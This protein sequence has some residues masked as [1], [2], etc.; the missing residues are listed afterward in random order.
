[1]MSSLQHRP[2][3]LGRLMFLGSLFAVAPASLAG[4]D[5][6]AAGA[7]AIPRRS[8]DV[9][10]VPTEMGTVHTMLKVAQ[11][12]KRDTVYDLGCGDGRIVITAVKEYGARR[13]VC[14]D[15][16]PERIK[17]SRLKADSA[18]VTKRIAFREADLFEMD[19]SKATVITL[20]LLPAL[21]E[22]LRPKLFRELRPGTRIVSNSFDMGDWKADS[23]LQPSPRSQFFNYAY[24][25]VIP[26]DVAGA[27][28]VT[29]EGGGGGTE[30]HGRSY[31]LKLEQRYQQI[32]GKASAN[33]R[34]VALDEVSLRGDR[35][36]F[37]IN[38]P[39]AGKAGAL[40]FSGK[41]TDDKA[42]GTVKSGA[43][44]GRSGSWTAT[45]TEKGPRPEIRDTTSGE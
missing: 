18:G 26:A 17:E 45:R 36:S 31:T 11:V 44:A 1:M 42:S 6:A 16:D 5:T 39:Q 9:H 8:P 7:A 28:N 14:V 23:V 25:W 19:L 33:G 20:Y 2:I 35:L 38:D 27:W 12:G 22:R 10:F 3:S 15:I 41:V 43:S 40:R 24:Y 13:G 29:M 21:N 32:T 30:G 4:Q 37:V 34:E